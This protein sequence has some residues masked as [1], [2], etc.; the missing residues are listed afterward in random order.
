MDVASFFIAQ[1]TAVVDR[2]DV[3]AAIA[4]LVIAWS[5]WTLAG[6]PGLCGYAGVLVLVIV[7]GRH[8]AG[9]G[10]KA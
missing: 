4:L 1:E 9:Q 8:I 3:I 7:V 2:W 5:V 6:V 10:D